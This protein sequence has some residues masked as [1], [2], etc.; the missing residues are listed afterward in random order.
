MACDR[1][2]RIR[3]RLTQAFAPTRLELTDQS[4]LHAGHAGTAS[5]GGHFSLVISAAVFN[6]K[7][8]LEQHRMI[9][10][11]LGELMQTDIHALQIHVM[12]T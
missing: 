9:Y 11:A 1:M 8:M 5:G 10:D 6:G 3:Q 4:H 12:R 2:E 7:M